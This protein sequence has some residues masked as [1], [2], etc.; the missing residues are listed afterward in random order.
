MG[1]APDLGAALLQAA[2]AEEGAVA[3]G[4]SDAGARAGGGPVVRRWK[5]EGGAA[6]SPWRHGEVRGGERGWGAARRRRSAVLDWS[7]RTLT[8][9]GDGRLRLR[10]ETAGSDFGGRR[11]SSAAVWSIRG[12][13]GGSSRKERAADRR[14][15]R[16]RRSG[17]G[18][19]VSETVRA[20]DA[21]ATIWHGGGEAQVR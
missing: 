19:G 1:A 3:H 21:G 12:G 15:W 10:L 16:V 17:G 6:G 4:G 13:A 14:R 11:E 8:S 9:T 7:R 5:E 18:A 2:H 20:L